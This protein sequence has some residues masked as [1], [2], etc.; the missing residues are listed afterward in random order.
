MAGVF[1]LVMPGLEQRTRTRSPSLAGAWCG[2]ATQ[3]PRTRT[4]SPSMADAPHADATQ[5]LRTRTRSGGQG[6][7]SGDA[8]APASLPPS[9]PVRWEAER[10][11][12]A[13][14]AGMDWI[15]REGIISLPNIENRPDPAGQLQAVVG[16]R[17]TPAAFLSSDTRCG[18]HHV[19]WPTRSMRS[20]R[21]CT[22]PGL[23]D[24][25]YHVALRWAPRGLADPLYHVAL[26][27]APRGL[28][29]PLYHVALR[30]APRG[31]ANPLYHVALRWAPRGLANPLYRATRPEAPTWA[32]QP[33]VACGAAVGT[34]WAGQPAVACGAAVGTTW[35]GQ[36]A[37]SRS[38]LHGCRLEWAILGGSG[39]PPCA[40]GAAPQRSP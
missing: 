12:L 37:V 28:A 27:W 3:G 40:H 31:L 6:G 9:H 2:D 32:G 29:D 20:T 1:F 8:P 24:P 34:T 16:R 38:T 35:A 26:R 39:G 5:G 4:R 11:A 25:L 15:E 21:P 36:P 14:S 13:A 30:W 22:P 18:G 33:A 7:P 19:G 23:A 10:S 17:H